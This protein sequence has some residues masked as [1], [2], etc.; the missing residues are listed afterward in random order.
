MARDDGRIT[1]AEI[2]EARER[3]AAQREEILTYLA[4]ELGGDP[5]DYTL[6]AHVSASDDGSD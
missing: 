5:E 6:Q 1:A 3:M 2:A 4:D